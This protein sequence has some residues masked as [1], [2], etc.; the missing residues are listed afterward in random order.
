MGVGRPKENYWQEALNQYA[1]R[2]RHYGGCELNFVRPE[3][4]SPASKPME[5]ISREGERLLKSMQPTDTVW[6]L[7]IQGHSLSS[8]QLAEKLD[9]ARSSRRL[10]VVVGGQLGLAPEIRERAQL[11]LSLGAVTLPHELAAV[12][13]LEQLFRAHTILAKRPYHRA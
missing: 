10:V 3:R 2:L 11:N 8:E 1:A 6:A 5:L 9:A 12:V 4:E 13:A 7:V